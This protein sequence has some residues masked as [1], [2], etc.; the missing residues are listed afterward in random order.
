MANFDV[1]DQVD[2]EVVDDSND[3]AGT[4]TSNLINRHRPS[5]GSKNGVQTKSKKAALDLQGTG[6]SSRTK[7]KSTSKVSPPIPSTSRAVAN[8]ADED[9]DQWASDA[10]DADRLSNGL[11]SV[12]ESYRMNKT[13]GKKRSRGFGSGRKGRRVSL[14]R[15]NTSGHPS[16]RTHENED[17][18]EIRGRSGPTSGTSLS[19][20]RPGMG[21]RNLSLVNQR[22]QSIRTEASR[23][24]TRESSP[25][26]SVRFADDLE[27]NGGQSTR[28]S[29]MMNDA[30]LPSANST[31]PRGI[32]KADSGSS[33]GAG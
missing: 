14:R 3:E 8:E 13:E 30:V 4:S 11:S 19:V 26:R 31:A 10:T 29:R 2:V 22:L 9:E 24:P 33:K 20:P 12:H 21:P 25:A 5:Q 28:G 27:E 18:S 6:K 32:E 16:R 7:R 23:L 15:L 17:G 1:I